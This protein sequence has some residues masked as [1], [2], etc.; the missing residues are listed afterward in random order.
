MTSRKRERTTSKASKT[1]RNRAEGSRKKL[2]EAFIADLDRRL[3]Q[4]MHGR[5]E[6]H[7]KTFCDRYFRAIRRR[8]RTIA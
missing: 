7:P 2:A 8:Q 3:L 5:T 4:E 6:S 1:R